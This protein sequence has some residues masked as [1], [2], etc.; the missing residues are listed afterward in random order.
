MKI[1]NNMQSYILRKLFSPKF[2]HVVK[3]LTPILAMYPITIVVMVVLSIFIVLFDLASAAIVAGLL[4]SSGGAGGSVAIPIIGKIDMFPS[5]LPLEHSLAFAVALIVLLQ[6]FRELL[7]FLNTYL[8]QKLSTDVEAI[9]KNAMTKTFLKG[10]IEKFNKENKSDLILQLHG[11]TSSLAGFISELIGTFNSFIIILMYVVS[12]LVLEPLPFIVLSVFLVSILVVTNWLVTRQEKLGADFREI[13]LSF[14]GKAVDLVYGLVEIIMGNAQR[15]FYEKQSAITDKLKVQRLRLAT[16]KLLVSPV[17]RSLG[18]VVIGILLVS[19]EFVTIGGEK[20]LSFESSM[21][22]LFLLMRMYGPISSFNSSRSTILSRL[23]GV[24]EVMKIVDEA[25]IGNSFA[26]NSETPIFGENTPQADYQ[27]PNE[28]IKFVDV[29]YSYDDRKVLKKVNLTLRA[30]RVTALVGAS[31]SGKSTIVNLLTKMFEPNA[32]KILCG[33]EDIKNINA[34]AWRNNI[35][36]I[37]Q[38]GHIFHGTLA[39]NISMQNPLLT[40]IDIEKA[41]QQAGISDYIE[42]LPEK[43]ETIIGGKQVALSGGQQQKLL[44]ARALVN[45]PKLLILDEATSAQ[46]ALSENEIL[47]CLKEVYSDLTILIIAH[48]FSAIRDARNI[49]LIDDGEIKESGSWKKLMSDDSGMFKT[50]AE[51]QNLSLNYEN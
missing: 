33:N 31:G 14:H 41:A 2:V 11:Y 48:R 37:A 17:Q 13:D 7:L 19:A 43:Y 1:N 12:L 46:D 40:K 16:A 26:Q 10:N 20:L 50:M 39:K 24:E 3:R 30:G 8:P 4:L 15:V 36:L 51:L 9:M 45:K 44:I 27:L 34:F 29:D 47:D 35:A 38:K 25:E 23:V 5:F 32:G 21:L 18:F 42:T 6:V 49:F 28:G 22:V